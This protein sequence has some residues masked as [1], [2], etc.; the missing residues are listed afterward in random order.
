MN[1]VRLIILSGEI[2]TGKS[3]ISKILCETHGFKRVKTSDFL[4][5]TAKQRGLPIERP[6]LQK[7]GTDLDDETNGKWVADLAAEQIEFA[8]STSPD[9]YDWLLDSAR[10]PE[11]AK[12]LRA[13]IKGSVLHFDVHAPLEIARERFAR[14]RQKASDGYESLNFDEAKQDYT[15]RLVP[16]L[17][18]LADY[19]IDSSIYTATQAAVFI[20][21]AFTETKMKKVVVLTGHTSTGKTGLA[22][23]LEREFAFTAVDTS[24]LIKERAQSAG[25]PTDRLSLQKHG[26]FLDNTTDHKWVC[27]HVADMFLS[28]GGPIV[29]DNIRTW[30]QLEQF[31]LQAGWHVDHVHLYAS[32]AVREARYRKLQEKRQDPTDAINYEEANLIKREADIGKFRDDADVRIFTERTDAEDTFVRVAARLKLFSPPDRRCVD[33]IIGGQYGSEGK[34]HVAGY[35]SKEY[36]V[37]V[38]VGGPNAGHTVSSE[39][40]IYTYHQLPS[41]SMDCNAE[42]LI[43]P[44]ATIF[45]PTLLKEIEECKIS[46]ERLFI[47]PQVMVINEADQQNEATLVQEIGSTGQGV[48]SASA[49]RIMLRQKGGVKLARDI[50]E[51]NKY[52][53]DS[54]RYRGSTLSRLEIAYRSGKSI[55]LEGTQGS[56]LSIYHGEYPYVTSRDTNVAGCLA[57]AGIS[58]NRVRRVVMVIRPTPIRVADPK[59]KDNKTSGALKH[60]T[61]FETVANMAGLLPDDVKNAEKTSTT[62][63]DRRVG[64]FDWELLRKSCLLNTPTDIALTFADYLSAEN[65]HARRFEQLN[66]DTIKFIEEIE[67]VSQAPV[68][69]I[70]TRFPRDLRE[71]FDLRTVIDRRNWKT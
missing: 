24:A 16:K 11:Q 62:G 65:Q 61:Q 15:E 14:R 32:T 7:L 33:V 49:R 48:G 12:H 50:P 5:A 67:R 66:K 6:V 31:R 45:V 38:R 69:L 56:A 18:A 34:G 60:E 21:D 52:V 63:R 59:G 13:V 23:R 58:P 39:S 3:S 25:Q 35:L 22:K 71:R 10:I 20:L 68:S 26:D 30:K 1:R 28:T 37:L 47:D 9:S 2:A 46:T 17:R 64:W 19:K 57:E 55:L 29:I 53:G 8:L 70:N 54:P 4:K 44:G 42:I 36:Q 27:D 41:G 40:G 51:L 43:G